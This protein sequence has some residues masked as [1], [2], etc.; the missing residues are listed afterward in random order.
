MYVLLFS[1]AVLQDEKLTPYKAVILFL[2]IDKDTGTG[3]VFDFFSATLQPPRRGGKGGAL[4][5]A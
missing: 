4:I 5:G 1:L 3:E 2:L